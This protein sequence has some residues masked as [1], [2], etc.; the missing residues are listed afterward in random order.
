MP[1]RKNDSPIG[2]NADLVASLLARIDQLVAQI[3]ARDERIDELLALVKAQN[4]R[5]CELET[6][7]GRPPKTP[8]NSSVPPSRGQKANAEPP[9]GKRRRKGRPG[10]AR[11]LAENPDATRRFYAK[12]CACGA[13]LSEDGQERAKEYDHIDIPPIRPITTRVELFRAACPCCKARVTASAPADMPEG[14]PFG[15]GIVSM[16]TYLHGCQMIGYKRLTEVCRG[17]FGLTVS[18]GAIANMLAR[19]GEAFAAPAERIAAEVRASEVIASDETSARVKGRTWW[20]WTFG[21]ATAVYH[22][23]APTRGK[24]VPT[25]F[26]GGVK[27]K[28]WLSD[29]LAAQLGHAEEHQFCLA[30]LIRDAQYAIDHGDTIFAPD[31]KA[32]LQDACAV[33]R[34]RPDLADATIA[35]HRRRLE[36]ELG[37]L[38]ALKPTDAEG[39]KLRDTVYVDCTDKL[40]A[41]LKRRD[42]EPT[43]NES[44]R[45]LRPSVIFRK[46][47]NGFRSEWG[48]QTYAALCSIVET[49]RRNGRS[50]LNAIRDALALPEAQAASVRQAHAG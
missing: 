27:P 2:D 50:A 7:S 33:G 22:V 24:C 12:H 38:L 36:K 26:L 8:D 41:F 21:C 18:Q 44:E 20:Q 3:S 29:R 31:F 14:T 1:E 49:G 11:K 15:P 23:I 43:N 32:L 42:V 5:I 40:F 30:H 46:V 37:R 35:T 39:R 25:D 17:L 45:A 34:R 16:I 10:V 47:T 9:T 13:A 48:A 19:A 6:K 28:M 4:A